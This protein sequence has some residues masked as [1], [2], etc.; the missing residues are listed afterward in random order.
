MG[1]P[2]LINLKHRSDHPGFEPGHLCTR[3]VRNHYATHPLFFFNLSH[4]LPSQKTTSPCTHNSPTQS[5]Q[6]NIW[7][8]S[9]SRFVPSRR[10]K[11]RQQKSQTF[12]LSSK[13][14]FLLT[15]TLTHI[16]THFVSP[17]LFWGISRPHHTHTNTKRC[18]WTFVTNLKH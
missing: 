13:Q 16:R 18:L 7:A 15:W 3:Q 17:K 5:S 2:K 12:A 11:A 9:T 1:N 10:T 6:N 4:S 14:L 8:A